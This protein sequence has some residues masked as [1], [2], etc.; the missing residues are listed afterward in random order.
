MAFLV[1]IDT[2]QAARGILA[3]GLAALARHI[4][5]LPR[6]DASRAESIAQLDDPAFAD[7]LMELMR[8]VLERG[9]VVN[10]T[11]IR[12]P[13]EF[14]R[15]HL[16]DSLACAGLPELESA[17][18]V[19]DVGSG[20]GFPGLP[21]AALFPEKRFTLIDSV[22]KKTEFVEHAARVLGL[23]NVRA[24][25]ARAES[26]GRAPALRE[27][28]DL[29]LCRAVGK[30]SLILE[31]ALPLV[32]VGG[33]AVFYKTASAAVEIE[34]SRHAIELLGGSAEVRIET[35]ACIDMLPDRNHALY[36]VRKERPTPDAYPR[37]AGTPA[38]T[39]L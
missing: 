1:N 32:R 23:G 16:F 38:K 9:A 31:Y 22:Q 4:G 8:L 20:A 25:H 17:Q 35:E 5:G 18:S 26:A 7:A 10:L 36:I 21:L 29:A 15:L 24:I 2:E 33:S 13:E 3:E 37:R 27:H 14:V 34:E 12:E 6:G 11:S 19:A 28:F 39:P 30:L